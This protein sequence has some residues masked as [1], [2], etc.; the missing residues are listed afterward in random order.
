MDDDI[1][2]CF[3]SCLYLW[4]ELMNSEN[5]NQRQTQ[6]TVVKT[7]RGPEPTWTGLAPTKQWEDDNWTSGRMVESWPSSPAFQLRPVS[8]FSPPPSSYHHHHHYHLIISSRKIII[9][10]I[11]ATD[12]TLVVF[13]F[14]VLQL[15]TLIH[16]MKTNS[17]DTDIYFRHTQTNTHTELDLQQWI[18]GSVGRFVLTA[19]LITQN[20]WWYVMVMGLSH[21]NGLYF[22]FYYWC[23]FLLKPAEL[24]AVHAVWPQNKQKTLHSCIK[25]LSDRSCG[26]RSRSNWW[27]SFSERRKPLSFRPYSL[28]LQYD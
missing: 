14:I 1:P 3:S 24:R 26:V 20:M 23:N 28:W 6:S 18:N 7:W 19:P 10:S 2:V 11:M 21:N 17:T 9:I 13:H 8:F 15:H 27:L 25:S 22:S 5:W 16:A 4:E 12:Y